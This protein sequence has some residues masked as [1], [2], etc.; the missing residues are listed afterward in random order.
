MP[1][2]KKNKMSDNNAGT[3]GAGT[4][5]AGDGI[6][7]GDAM[8]PQEVLAI[9]LARDKF[10]EWLGLEI[11][12]VGS[13][14][15]RLHYRI[16]EDMLNGFSQVHGGVLFSAADSAFAFACNSHGRITVALDV[17]ITFRRA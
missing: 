4:G 16:R 3:P 11:D 12:E 14:Y 10:T 1:F 8:T 9:M 2:L 6:R 15:C 5:G 13:G 17:S 7:S